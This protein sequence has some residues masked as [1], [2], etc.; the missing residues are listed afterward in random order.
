MTVAATCPECDAVF[1]V[2]EEH[3][4]RR[5]RCKQC[6][7]ICQVPDQGKS[8]RKK[9]LPRKK[10]RATRPPSKQRP[11]GP[12]EPVDEWEQDDYGN[13]EY[14]YDYDDYEQY[15]DYEAYESE[16]YRSARTSRRRTGKKR[17]SAGH[18]ALSVAGI[19]GKSVGSAVLRI[20]MLVGMAIGIIIGVWFLGLAASMVGRSSPELGKTAGTIL[21]IIAY[22]T[23]LVAS[24]AILGLAFQ[25]GVTIG[26]ACLLIPLYGAYWTLSRW[27][28]TRK[29]IGVNLCAVALGMIGMGL[30][31]GAESSA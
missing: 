25:E 1:R 6:S 9:A 20:A 16:T 7:A 21:T 22:A 24:I 2:G 13:D 12:A 10:H 31:M 11:Q 30:I 26:L 17:R 5:F 19:A 18:K 29:W 27:E 14:S 23:S 4:G 3:A 15:E 8:E 28:Y